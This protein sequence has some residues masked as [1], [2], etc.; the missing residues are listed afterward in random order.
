M[1]SIFDVPGYLVDVLGMVDLQMAGRPWT[2]SQKYFTLGGRHPWTWA[3]G[4][5]TSQIVGR[6][7]PVD[8]V[9]TISTVHIAHRRKSIRLITDDLSFE[10]TPGRH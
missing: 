6:V 2:S 9:D 10:R 8:L 7:K 4:S 1:S 5:P 3:S